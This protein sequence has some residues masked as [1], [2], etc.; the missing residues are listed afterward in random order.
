MG[1]NAPLLVDIG[2][3]LSLMIGLPRIA[4]WETLNRPENP[5]R[6]IFGFNSQTNTLEYFDG[7]SW[8]EAPLSEA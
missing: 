6:G 3:G 2:S 4:T 8:F 7:K 1:K 5:K